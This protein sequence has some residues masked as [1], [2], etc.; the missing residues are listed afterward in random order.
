MGNGRHEIR[1]K[2]F[3]DER[4]ERLKR[5]TRSLN[6]EL[7]LVGGEPLD[8]LEAHADYQGVIDDHEGT[9]ADLARR[10]AAERTRVAYVEGDD[11]DDDLDTVEDGEGVPVEAD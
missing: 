2:G 7:A 1:I 3:T 8:L 10:L 4:M 11:R 6:A 5:F 9:W